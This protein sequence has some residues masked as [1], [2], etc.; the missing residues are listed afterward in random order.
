MVSVAEAARSVVARRGLRPRAIAVLLAMA[1]FGLF[2]GTAGRLTGYENETAAVSEGLVKTGQLRVLNGTPLGAQ[3]IFG[4]GGHYYSRTGSTQPLLE[5]P[6]YWLGEQLDQVS[7]HGRDDRW[8]LTLLQLFDPA[9]AALTVVAIFALLLLRGVSERRALLI[10]ALCA[11]G[12]LIWPYS[13][14]GMDTTLMAMLALT[15]LTATWTARRPTTGRLALLGCAAAMTMNSKPYGALLLLG[16]LPLFASSLV[17]LVRKRR[18]RAASCS[19]RTTAFPF[20]LRMRVSSSASL[21]DRSVLRFPLLSGAL[22][23]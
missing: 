4:R 18:T 6:A 3:G 16:L 8:R 1:A 21:T 19:A 13:K 5:V 10:A 15:A 23:A 11:V 22:R 12:T 14:I 17:D 7:S 20:S 2:G 9:M